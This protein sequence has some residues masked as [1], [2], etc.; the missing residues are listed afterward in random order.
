M[1]QPPHSSGPL[2][3]GEARSQQVSDIPRHTAGHSPV[4]A[5]LKAFPLGA[6]RWA[7]TRAPL[8]G[9]VGTGDRVGSVSA[10]CWGWNEVVR[11]KDKA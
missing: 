6:S 11:E 8:L 10:L 5:A 1:P 9:T 4:M 3:R 7:S 2:G